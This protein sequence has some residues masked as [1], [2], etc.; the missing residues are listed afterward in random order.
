MEVSVL[1]Y[2]ILFNKASEQIKPL[3]QKYRPDIVC[4]QEIITTEENLQNLAFDQY[5]LAD[6]SNSFFKF[7]KIFGVATYF[8]RQKLD[9]VRSES[10][11][12]PRS[13]L[14]GLLIVL[15]GGNNPRN[16]LKTK[17]RLKSGKLISVYTVHLSPWG[18]NGIRFKQVKETLADLNKDTSETAIIAGDFNYPYGRKKFEKLIFASN[19]KEATNNIPYTL[20]AKSFPFMSIRLKLDYILYKNIDLIKTTRID[21]RFSDHYPIFSVFDI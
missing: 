15:R 2:N 6:F 17:F 7:N 12:L 11:N 8:N 9:L 10:F 1:T 14:E 20:E 3:V 19:L 4:L 18:S 21:C 13:F 5:Q 16:V